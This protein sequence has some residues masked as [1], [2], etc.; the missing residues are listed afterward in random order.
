[1]CLAIYALDT[2]EYGCT[3]YVK[4]IACGT[5]G[6]C[7]T[8]LYLA[9]K[10]RRDIYVCWLGIS[11]DVSNHFAGI[12]SNWMLSS[13]EYLYTHK[14]WWCWSV[15][16]KQRVHFN[17]S[18]YNLNLKSLRNMH[19]CSFDAHECRLIVLTVERYRA[20]Y[21]L[22]PLCLPRCMKK[23]VRGEEPKRVLEN[24]ILV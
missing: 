8:R 4:W 11:T 9:V 14:I 10:I 1:M 6:F 23:D 13:F 12:F 22:E 17:R 5:S 16:F 24:Y 3:F 15:I 21:F 7:Q 19:L 20:W 18:L 2:Y